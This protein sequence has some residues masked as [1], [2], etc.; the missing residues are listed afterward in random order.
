M[1]KYI[2][3]G[4]PIKHS[5]SPQIHHAFAQ[6]TGQSMDYSMFEIALGNFASYMDNFFSEKGCGVNITV[7]FKQDAYQYADVL[8][9]R[10]QLAGA[11]NTLKRQE[12]GTIL[13][14]NTDG[15]GL[16]KDLLAHEVCLKG[17]RILLIGAGGAARGVIYPLLQQLPKNM[18]IVNRTREKALKLAQHFHTYGPIVGFGHDE[19]GAQEFD[20]VI[21]ATSASLSGNL[22]SI[23]TSI[24]PSSCCVYDMMYS[25]NTTVFNQWATKHGARL[26]LDGLGMLVGQAAE[27]FFIWRN[28]YPETKPVLMDMRKLLDQEK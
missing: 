15:E 26:C 11:V 20:L 17:S 4:N 13:G 18:V 21:N 27:S 24:F 22:P 16:V 12:D 2:V 7:P 10:A 19:I 6:Q 14:D 23:P 28:I 8:S 25:S 5:K 9:T 3:V 1:D